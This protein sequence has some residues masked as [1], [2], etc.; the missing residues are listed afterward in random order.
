MKTKIEA[1]SGLYFPSFS[2]GLSLRVHVGRFYVR[3]RR[4]FPFLFGGTFI[5]GVITCLLAGFRRDFPSFS[6]GLSLRVA[7]K[8]IDCAVPM[9]T[10]PFLFGGTFIEGSTRAHI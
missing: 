6:E 10:F 8:V 7:R 1:A 5:E 4:T 3:Y 2:E 9:P